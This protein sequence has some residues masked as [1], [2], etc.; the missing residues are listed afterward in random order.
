MKLLE[1][2]AELKKKKSVRNGITFAAILISAIM[3][4]FVIQTFV[5][6]AEILSGGF[7]GIAILIEMVTSRYG[8][9]F[10][11]SLGMLAINIPVA[12]VCSR[13]IGMRFTGFSLLHVFITSA[14]LQLCHFQPIFDDPI[15]NVIFGG[16]LMG[17][18]MVIA[19][20]ANAST[21][22][23]DFIAL[24]VSNKTGQSIWGK[25]FVGNIIL[26]CIFGSMFG[27]INAAYSILFQFVSTRTISTFHHRYD[28][29]T[30]QITTKKGNELMN[31]YI[32][33]FRHGISC[34]D[35]V[36]GYS[37]KK[38][39]L[40]HT[41]ISSYE[42]NDV[43]RLMQEVDPQVIINVFKTDQFHGKFYQAPLN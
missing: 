3:Q 42:V 1:Q 34:V 43:V 28:R 35:A 4:A 25:V 19:L 41:V 27:W 20:K 8:I 31:A 18:T 21:G 7:T 2:A 24:Y 23:T 13:S 22:G 12:F 9:S 29:V 6:P 26:Y 5:R 37:K 17:M 36:G 16:F 39:F 11:T 32:K 14:L 30:L 40:L 38:M 33:T 10:S 15:L